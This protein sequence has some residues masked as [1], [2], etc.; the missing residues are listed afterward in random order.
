MDDRDILSRINDLDEEEH[1]LLT[2]GGAKMGLDEAERARLH[3]LHVELDQLSD[4]VRQRRARRHAGLDPDRARLRS[5]R[6]VENY[7]H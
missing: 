5:A 7:P 1:Q 3:G 6:V 2:R 4:L